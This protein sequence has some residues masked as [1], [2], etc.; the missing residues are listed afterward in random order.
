M[1]SLPMKIT[2]ALEACGEAGIYTAISTIATHER[3]QSGELERMYQLGRSWGVSE[4]RILA[5]VAT[6]GRSG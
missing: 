4:F 5:P 2:L 3:L 1:Y 6:G